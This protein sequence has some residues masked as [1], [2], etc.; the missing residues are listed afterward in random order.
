M[1]LW[2]GVV[3]KS[4]SRNANDTVKRI[5]CLI[6]SLALPTAYARKRVTMLLSTSFQHTFLGR[7]M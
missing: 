2:N 4:T 3:R 7:P 5:E 1:D 6:A